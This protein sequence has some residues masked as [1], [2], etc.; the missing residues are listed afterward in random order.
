MGSSSKFEEAEIGRNWF[1]ASGCTG[2]AN[3]RCLWDRRE[4][5]HGI[6]ACV[7]VCVRACVCRLVRKVG[8]EI[9][10]LALWN[11]VIDLGRIERGRRSWPTG[12]S[13]TIFWLPKRCNF[14]DLEVN[15]DNVIS[16]AIRRRYTAPNSSRHSIVKKSLSEI[17]DR[18]KDYFI[19][20]I[21][22]K[23]F[24]GMR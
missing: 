3:R 20:K 14:T 1:S 16:N 5:W 19:R 21:G 23:I 2:V 15:S 12:Y 10:A 6:R 18:Q 8:H 7:C 24:T 17:I 13:G 9:G 11:E 22:R 4:A